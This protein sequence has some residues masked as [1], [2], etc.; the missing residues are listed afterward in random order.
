MNPLRIPLQ[1]V[2]YEEEGQWVAHCLQ[3]DLVGVAETKES[4]IN[5]LNE[6]IGI[7]IRNSIESGNLRNLFTPAD[8]EYF[9]RFAEASDI[10]ESELRVSIEP[11]PAPGVV[12]ER[13]DVREF[14]HSPGRNYGD[15]VTA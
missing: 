3:F 11:R 5:Q 9:Q 15:L 6:A 10:A 4:A 14:H 12:F 7:Q 13:M 2:F 1:V 8:S